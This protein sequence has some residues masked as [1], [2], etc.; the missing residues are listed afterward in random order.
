[1]RSRKQQKDR[2][3]EKARTL[4]KDVFQRNENSDTYQVIQL[5]SVISI[6]VSSRETG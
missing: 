3:L 5:L 4:S 6:G 2:R 1:M